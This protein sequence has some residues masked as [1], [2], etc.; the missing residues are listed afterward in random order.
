M[1]SEI[2][3]TSPTSNLNPEDFNLINRTLTDYDDVSG[4]HTDGIITAHTIALHINPSKFTL[5]GVR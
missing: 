4:H 1:Q 5:E 2:Y 3:P